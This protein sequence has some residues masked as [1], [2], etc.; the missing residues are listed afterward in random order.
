M[1]HSAH[2]QGVS[3]LGC[4]SGL[5]AAALAARVRAARA[6]GAL[7][8]RHGAGSARPL[9]HPRHLQRGARLPA[10]PSGDDGGAA[11]LRLQ[12]RP[13]LVASARPGLRGTGR[14][15]GGDRPEPAGLPHHRRLPQ[16]PPRGPVGPI[17]AGAAPVP[18]G[19]S[20][21]VRPRGGGRDQGEGQRLPPQGDELRTHEDRRAGPGRRSR[22]L[23]GASARG[24]HGR[25]CGAGRE[26]TGRRDAGL[27]GRQAATAGD[28]PRRQGRAGSGSDRSARP[29]GRERSGCILGHALAGSAPAR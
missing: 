13:V 8:S 27:D 10:L 17:R 6:H 9:G 2:G 12:P 24:G 3:L 19:W 25:G 14:R 26:P 28:D 11:A 20:G 15:H 21:P 4:G 29:R 23:V 18:R 22:R 5:V 16:A 1:V 7:R